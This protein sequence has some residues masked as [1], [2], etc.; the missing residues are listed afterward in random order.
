MEGQFDVEAEKRLANAIR[1]FDERVLNGDDPWEV[2]DEIVDYDELKDPKIG[3]GR[4]NKYDIEDAE[5]RL[6]E[7]AV[8]GD[9]TEELYD[10]QMN[11]IREL[12][13][14]FQNM[15]EFKKALKEEKKKGQR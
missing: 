10:Q 3:D 8:K 11:Y 15:T 5:T 2:A 6:N 1:V 7:K 9:I 4:G 12:K 14:K 13:A